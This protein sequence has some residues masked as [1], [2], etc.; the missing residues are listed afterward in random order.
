MRACL[1]LVPLAVA[2]LL[3]ACGSPDRPNDPIDG[4]PPARQM[5]ISRAQLGFRWPLTPGTGTLA[6][7]KDGAILFRAGGVLYAVAGS[8]PGAADI[9]PI[10][11]REPSPP[12]SNPVKRL[13]QNERMDAF[14][15]L[16]RCASARSENE[17]RRIVQQRFGLSAE[18]ARLIE[19]EGQER[20]WP[21]LDR[22]FMTLGPLAAAG[23]RLCDR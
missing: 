8:W 15:S 7:A 5:T 1:N 3:T 14:V 18:E 22:A 16:E 13:K 12:S 9:T 20:R 19:A 23:R 11:A 17:C 4:I 2:A 21:P 10:R 6:C